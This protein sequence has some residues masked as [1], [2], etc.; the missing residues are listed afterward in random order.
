MRVRD[1]GRSLGV[2]VGVAVD[3]PRLCARVTAARFLKKFEVFDNLAS[4]FPEKEWKG[5]D[6]SGRCR[7]IGTTCEKSSPFM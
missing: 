3:W 4:Q 7:Q 2:T 1:L 6:T 5:K